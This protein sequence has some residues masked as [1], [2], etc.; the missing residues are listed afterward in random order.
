M[1]NDGGTCDAQGC[2]GTP[3]DDTGGWC[4]YNPHDDLCEEVNMREEDGDDVHNAC[5]TCKCYKY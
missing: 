4:R 5:Y 2:R 1:K 3:N